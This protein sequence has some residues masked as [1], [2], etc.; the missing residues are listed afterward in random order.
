MWPKGLIVLENY[1]W[2]TNRLVIVWPLYK[3]GESFKA[4]LHD[5]VQ[6][7]KSWWSLIVFL[8]SAGG[9][10]RLLK[11]SSPCSSLCTVTKG[12]RYLMQSRVFAADKPDMTGKWAFPKPRQPR[13]ALNKTKVRPWNKQDNYGLWCRA[14]VCLPVAFIPQTL[15]RNKSPLVAEQHLR[16]E[17]ILRLRQMKMN[18]L[19]LLAHTKETTEDWELCNR[20]WTI[21]KGG[22]GLKKTIMI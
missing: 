20:L 1:H 5:G 22:R 10:S 14:P 13:G 4:S 18:L 9:F 15:N 17:Q 12:L 3:N 11:H 7:P 6:P 21:Q 19:F 16:A 2:D 8:P